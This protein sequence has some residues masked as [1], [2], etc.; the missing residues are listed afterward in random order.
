MSA[1]I[2]SIACVIVIAAASAVAQENPRS[3]ATRQ[4]SDTE[5]KAVQRELDRQEGRGQAD[6]IPVWVHVITAGAGYENGEISDTNVREQIRAMDQTFA[7]MLGGDYTGFDFDLK[8]IT[9]TLNAEW[10]SMTPG[11]DA[12]AEAKAALRRGGPE[13]LNLYTT[14]GGG[15]LGWATFPWWYQDD[16]SGDGIVVD[17]RSLPGGPYGSNYSLGYTATHEVGHWLALFHTFQDSCSQLNDYVGDTPAEQSPASGC[18]V[19]RDTC[20]GAKYAGVDPIHNFMDYSYDSCYTQFTGGQT[21]RMRTA[22]VTYR[23]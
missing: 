7:G 4:V 21:E 14:A 11:S 10:F 6:R 8:G 2:V 20:V 19:G 22:W 1:R 13:T 18:P 15:Y 5:A 12:E 3:C 16:P 17:F 23:D 9:R